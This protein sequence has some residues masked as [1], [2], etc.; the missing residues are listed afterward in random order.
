MVK[1]I[2]YNSDLKKGLYVISTPIGNLG[3]ITL[4]SI[5]I[6]KKSDFILCEDTRV[7]KKLLDKFEIKTKLISNHKFNEVK[8]LSKLIKL[9]KQNKIVSMISDAGTPGI[10]DPGSIL[11]NECLNE[12]INVIPLP[13]PSAVTTAVSIS[14]FDDKY[15]F[16]GF[17]PDRDKMIKEELNKL[18][19]LN[20]C[21]VFFISPK[22]INKIIPY[23]K[24]YFKDRKIL[25]CREI[26]KYY[27]E[28]IRTSIQKLEKFKNEPKGELTLV[29]SEKIYSKKN[30]QILS[31]SDKS[32]IKKMINKLSTKEITNLISH[33]RKISK[34][35]IYDYCL[36][37]K[38]EK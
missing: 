6:L 7:S 22:K 36:K 28:F 3:D 30:S 16:Y 12:N 17:F 33:N 10:S 37:L 31:E 27:E 35:E 4:R 24:D 8:N 2:L 26:S 13:G 25:I 29:I 34:K 1:P 38:N 18:S 5:E 11:V 21:L 23:L 19:N 20:F 15:L 32:N 9:L 14:G